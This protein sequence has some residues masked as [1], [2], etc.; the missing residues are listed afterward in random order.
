VMLRA[1]NQVC[2]I[3]SFSEKMPAE[4]TSLKIWL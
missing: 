2:L 3:R 4:I 1:K